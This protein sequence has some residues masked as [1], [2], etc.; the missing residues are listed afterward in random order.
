MLLHE[1]NVLENFMLCGN[2]FCSRMTRVWCW[3]SSAVDKT[4]T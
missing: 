3:T 4:Q 2:I 1:V